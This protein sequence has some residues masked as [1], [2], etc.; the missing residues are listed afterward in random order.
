MMSCIGRKCCGALLCRGGCARRRVKG[1]F[2][3]GLDGVQPRPAKKQ[4]K[5]RDMQ[6]SPH[7]TSATARDCWSVFSL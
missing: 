7:K 6:G 2:E 4:V 1:G 3:V 5:Q